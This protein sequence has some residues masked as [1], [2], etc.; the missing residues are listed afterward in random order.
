MNK[1]KFAPLLALPLIAAAPLHAQKAPA[2]DPL[3]A[4]FRAHVSFLA[5]DLL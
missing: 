2:A 1:T 5:D 3:A 4:S